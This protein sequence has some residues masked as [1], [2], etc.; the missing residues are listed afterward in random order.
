MNTTVAH[1]LLFHV[2]ASKEAFFIK[3]ALGS[4]DASGEITLCQ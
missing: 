4:P 3:A 2:V 1:K